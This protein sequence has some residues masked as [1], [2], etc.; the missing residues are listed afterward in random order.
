MGQLDLLLVRAFLLSRESI[1]TLQAFHFFH[2][3]CYW[4]ICRRRF[5]S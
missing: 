2:V 4:D 3:R 5:Y 1:I